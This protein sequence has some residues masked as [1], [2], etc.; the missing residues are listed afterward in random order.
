MLR[1]A[2]EARDDEREEGEERWAGSR[3]ERF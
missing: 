2:N 1:Q 3:I